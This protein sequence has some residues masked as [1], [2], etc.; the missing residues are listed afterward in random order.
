M[1]QLTNLLFRSTL[2]SQKHNRAQQNYIMI[3]VLQSNGIKCSCETL[4]S[5]SITLR[6]QILCI[7]TCILR[8]CILAHYWLSPIIR[9]EFL[10]VW[11]TLRISR[12]ATIIFKWINFFSKD[13]FCS[14]GNPIIKAYIKGVQLIW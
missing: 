13:S 8:P 14:I 9:S 10:V 7:L 4:Q 2:V 11:S 5:L 12:M 1:F 6:L 3:L